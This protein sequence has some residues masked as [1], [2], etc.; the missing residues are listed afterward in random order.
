MRR[1]LCS[2]IAVAAL[3]VASS[4]RAEGTYTVLACSPGSPG[5]PWGLVN[6]EN[7]C[8]SPGIVADTTSA[9]MVAFFAPLDTSIAGYRLWRTVRLTPASHYHLY[10]DS[11]QQDLAESCLSATCDGLGDGHTAD[12]PDVTQ[13]GLDSHEIVMDIGCDPIE[14]NERCRDG[15]AASLT[16]SR[17]D[18]D[19]RDGATPEF[20]GTPSGDLLD[21]AQPIAGVRTE[22]FSAT[23]RGS[24][25]YV[26]KLVVD[27]KALESKVMD[28]NGGKCDA[29]FTSVV[30]CK[31]AA[32]GS[33]SL[34]T[35]KLRDGVHSMSLEVYD[36]TESNAATFGP[37]RVRTANAAVACHTADTTAVAARLNGTT[38]L[39]VT[40]RSG[41]A[42]IVGRVAGV[43]AKATVALIGRERLTG[44]K[45][46]LLGSVLTGAH[47]S[48]SLPVPPGP[49]RIIHA[50]YKTSPTDVS[51]ACSR[52]LTIHV[53]AAATLHA[54][55]RRVRP[56]ARVRLYGRLQGNR[57][58]ARG[59]LIALQ[60]RELGRWRTFATRHTTR[61]GSFSAHHR[62]RSGTYPI[63]VR[64]PTASSY[65]YALGY[66]K[67]VR[68]RVR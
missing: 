52:A 56:G 6:A 17:F 63:R 31:Q 58:P 32:S 45:P 4:A 68:V 30:P 48:F 55:P 67:S 50:A 38:H 2:L 33:L 18:V 25:V 66:S 35:A 26:A 13:S 29:P 27:G 41:R 15:S 19:L 20:S 10:N 24:G 8:P 64:V 43:G 57:I 23:D 22:S 12:P 16:V 11:R 7:D 59:K 44:A 40:R 37:V 21:A 9:A 1:V 47:G 53:P 28:G 61:S 42:T 14:V 49:S 46:A 34:D 60:A 39:A 54:S 36:A 3:A 51:Y 65:P 62:F 5:Q